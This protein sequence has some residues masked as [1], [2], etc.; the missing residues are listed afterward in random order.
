MKN[1]SIAVTDEVFAKNIALQKNHRFNDVPL[2]LNVEVSTRQH[3]QFKKIAEFAEITV[4]ELVNSL[5]IETAREHLR[6]L[7]PSFP[8]LIV[9]LRSC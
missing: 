4:E 1:L 9:T 6:R 3:A 2:T 5:L 7:L 8:Q